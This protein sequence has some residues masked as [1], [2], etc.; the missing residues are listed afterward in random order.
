MSELL[1]HQALKKAL[2]H[3]GVVGEELASAAGI[4]KTFVSDIRNGK[5]WMSEETFQKILVA[6][7]SL[8]PGS[9][10]YFCTLLA[11]ASENCTTDLGEKLE[12]LIEAADD[13]DIEKAM[14]AIAKRWRVAKLQGTLLRV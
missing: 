4:H 12:Q 13:E 1:P 5:K 14:L 7:D 10:K 9:R 3:Y 11:G 2:D 6:M 8:K